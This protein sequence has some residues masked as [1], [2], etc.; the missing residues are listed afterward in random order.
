MGG[1][2]T[3]LHPIASRGCLCVIFYEPTPFSQAWRLERHDQHLIYSN[4][5]SFFLHQG[6][7]RVSMCTCIMFVLG[8]KGPIGHPPFSPNQP[9]KA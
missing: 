5:D 3:K 8:H 4:R 6:E 2:M 7:S 1:E 9:L